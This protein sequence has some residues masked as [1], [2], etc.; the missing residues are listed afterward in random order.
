MSRPSRLATTISCLIWAGLVLLWVVPLAKADDAPNPF[1]VRHW[2]TDDGLPQNQVTC[3]KQTSNGY[4]WIGTYS[5]LA[6]FDGV[7]FTVFTQRNTPGLAEDSIN[8]LAEDSEGTLWIATAKGL[9]VYREGHFESAYLDENFRNSHVDLLQ[10]GRA[11]GIWMVAGM[12]VAHLERGRVSRLWTSGKEAQPIVSISEGADGWLNLFMQCAWLALSPSGDG[13]RTNSAQESRGPAWKVGLPAR[14]PRQ[15]WVGT[16]QGLRH[17]DG[18]DWR[19]VGTEH[20]GSSQVD[21]VFEDHSGNLWVNGHGELFGLWDGAHWR[22]IDFGE[23]FE[24]GTAS[25]VEEDK[26]GSIWVGAME[27]LVQLRR[28]LVQTYTTRNGLAHNRAWS[29]CEATEGTIWVGTQGGLSRIPPGGMI[30]PLPPGAVSNYCD[31]CVWP[32]DKGGV[33]TARN[34]L[35]LFEFQT[36][37]L[38]EVVPGSAL[39]GPITALW[40]NR[41]NVLFVCTAGGVLGFRSDQPVPWRDPLLRYPV[42]EVRAIL[43]DRDGTLWLGTD[44]KGLSR[45]KTGVISS[46]T[47]REG[48]S[49][50]NV[51]ALHLDV[52]GALWLGTAHGL[53]RYRNGKFFAFGPEQGL[54]E[55]TV[56]WILEDQSGFLWLSGLQ[57]IY[58]VERA[59]LNAVADGRAR[60]VDPFVLGTADGMER[61]ET[62]GE[63]QPAGWKARDGRLWFPTVRGVVVIDPGTIPLREKPPLVVLEQVKADDEVVAEVGNQMAG[64]GH[65]KTGRLRIGPGRAHVLEIQYTANSFGDPKRVRF[66]YRLVG[67]G[68]DWREQ[69]GERVVRY[70]N[71]RPGDYHFEVTAANHHNVWNSK[72]TAF[73]FSL[74]AHFWQTGPFY[75]LCVCGVFGLAAGVQAY[76]L[77]W[78]HRLLKLEEQRALASERTR[79]ARDLHDDLGTA[80]TG[81]A[82]ELDVVGRE[83][84]ESPRAERL[85]GTA[86]RTRALAERMREVVWTVNPN[87]DTVSSLADFLEQQVS[88]FLRS[89]GIRVRL[90]FPEDIPSLP[91]GAEAR[92]HLALSVREALTNVVRHAQ[93]TEVVLSIALLENG[94]D[95]GG[96]RGGKAENNAF[97]ASTLFA[98]AGSAE[99]PGGQTLVVQVKDNGRGFRPTEKS[100]H[101]LANMQSRLQQVGGSF[102]CASDGRG[103]TVVTFRLPLRVDK[104]KRKPI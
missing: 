86:Q 17:W 87:C 32:N 66:R 29:V 24:K 74:A 70:L 65:Q 45:I 98:K 9:V 30:Q 27:G 56:N 51:Y 97:L 16:T 60:T 5:G 75:A 46:F 7:R 42:A 92:H 72:P 71:L 76:R 93:A 99:M 37:R 1:M 80:L 49:N 73:D 18:K 68:S 96:N 101:G 26:E 34:N 79:I 50:S 36:A 77:R 59:A 78:Q 6:R 102:E 23:G 19:Q 15:A 85:A 2:T 12:R 39:P 91:L 58:R 28:P 90:E 11:G 22:P 31:R 82:L 53:T 4:L 63:K 84:K 10:S 69:T 61:A 43:A 103:G 44:G 55:N 33:W 81:L 25:C 38:A 94:R 95:S 83:T 35:G 88:Q 100:G 104:E 40:K 41:S 47:E 3:L 52:E 89:D 57:G 8:A 20:F 54:L 67:A 21:L 48:L 64:M 14:E 13:V 62:N